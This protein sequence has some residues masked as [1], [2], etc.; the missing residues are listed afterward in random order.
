MT[1]R[2]Y[3]FVV[4]NNSSELAVEQA[5]EGLRR[6]VE[7]GKKAQA[8][9]DGLERDGRWDKTVVWVAQG[10]SQYMVLTRGKFPPHRPVSRD[11]L[12][13]MESLAFVFGKGV[14]ESYGGHAGTC[15]PVWIQGQGVVDAGGELLHRQIVCPNPVASLRVSARA[16][17]YI[18]N[19]SA[20]PV[21]VKLKGF[22]SMLAKVGRQESTI[23]RVAADVS[24]HL[25]TVAGNQKE[26]T[27]PGADL[28]K[29]AREWLVQDGHALRMLEDAVRA[30]CVMGVMDD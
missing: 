5:V 27:Q 9:L 6:T 12:P 16:I 30:L 10:S 28:F 14:K 11:D 24:H 21:T 2:K 20:W 26:F 13:S 22:D 18:S 15:Y 3:P 17:S 19:S 29:M 4:G 7:L 25:V 8:A 23:E 1:E